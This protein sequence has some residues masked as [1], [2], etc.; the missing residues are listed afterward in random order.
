MSV[1]SCSILGLPEFLLRY[2][3][4]FLEFPLL[5]RID[6]RLFL[7]HNGGLEVLLGLRSPPGQVFLGL[8]VE[9]HARPFLLFDA[10]L[11]GKLLPLCGLLLLGDLAAAWEDCVADWKLQSVFGFFEVVLLELLRELLSA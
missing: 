5:E 6:S 2:S 10:L 8:L 4:L 3:K 11:L 1:T 9:G 7:F